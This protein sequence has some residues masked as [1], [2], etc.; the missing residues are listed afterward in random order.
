MSRFSIISKIF[1]TREIKEDFSFGV[2]N[3]W[4]ALVYLKRKFLISVI[5]TMD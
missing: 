1:F 3:L 2:F 4:Q 5:F